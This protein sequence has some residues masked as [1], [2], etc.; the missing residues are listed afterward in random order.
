MSG[1]D[2]GSPFGGTDPMRE[3][4]ERINRDREAF[5]GD[6]IGGPRR[7]R[8][9]QESPFFRVRPPPNFTLTLLGPLYPF[10][11]NK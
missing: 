4:R 1:E 7:M 10:C 6:D 8:W 3:M 11:P 5:F 2:F 9:P